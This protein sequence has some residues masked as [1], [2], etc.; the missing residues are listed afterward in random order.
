MESILG[1]PYPTGESDFGPHCF[2]ACQRIFRNIV[3]SMTMRAF[4]KLYIARQVLGIPRIEFGDL[5][6]SPVLQ[7]RIPGSRVTHRQ[8]RARGAPADRDRRYAA[9]PIR[10]QLIGAHNRRGAIGGQGQLRATVIQVECELERVAG[11]APDPL[12][13]RSPPRS[14]D[15]V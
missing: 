1:K 14:C 9:L 12:A 5:S 8:Q 13:P 10:R 11:L 7:Q 4:E 15:G 6:E 2:V 3:N